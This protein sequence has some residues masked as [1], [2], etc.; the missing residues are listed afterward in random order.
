MRLIAC[1]ATLF[2]F[3]SAFSA[4]APAP[5]YTLHEW[6]VLTVA[7]GNPFAQQDMREEWRTFPK[8]FYRGD[9]GLNPPAVPANERVMRK[10]VIWLHGDQPQDIALTVRFPKG[11]PLVWWPYAVLNNDAT[12]PALTFFVS[13]L[14]RKP[15]DVMPPMLEAGHWFNRLCTVPG[16]WLYCEHGKQPKIKSPDR[17][18]IERSPFLYY[19]GLIPSPEQ[20]RVKRSEQ[21]IEIEFDVQRQLSDLLVIDRHDG[22]VSMSAWVDGIEIDDA[23]PHSEHIKVRLEVANDDLIAKRELELMERLI[24]AGLTREEASALVEIWRPQFFA[25]DGL[26]IFYRIPQERYEEMLPLTAEPAPSE[27]I[28]VGLVVHSHLEPELKQHVDQLI[29]DLRDPAK[30]AAARAKLAAY[31]GAAFD[32]LTAG[33]FSKPDEVALI[34]SALL[35]EQNMVPIETPGKG[36]RPRPAE[37]PEQA[38][39]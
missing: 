34:C 39:E 8:F 35:A 13:L 15:A 30:R 27:K 6:G 4:D 28:R 2:P 38:R 16:D 25:Q 24:G 9:A 14:P 7:K 5:T 20:P 1:I 31:G 17:G 36:F 37:L 19:D 26:T 32:G 3:L 18:P 10:P 23:P 22:T 11:R 33:M 12:T 21:G 29:I